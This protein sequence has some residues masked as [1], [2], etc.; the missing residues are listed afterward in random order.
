M[1]LGR[2]MISFMDINS[3]EE[4]LT[5]TVYRCE[6]ATV[7]LPETTVPNQVLA[8]PPELYTI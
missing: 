5:L 4:Y 6:N 1:R 7:D 3:G 8:M 2:G